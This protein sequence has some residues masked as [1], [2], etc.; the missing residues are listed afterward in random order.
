MSNINGN[1]YFKSYNMPGTFMIEKG[2]CSLRVIQEMN[3]PYVW[4]EFMYSDCVRYNN[5]LVFVPYINAEFI[6]I[7]DTQSLEFTYVKNIGLKKLYGKVKMWNQ[8]SFLTM[9]V[10]SIT[11]CIGLI[12]DMEQYAFLTLKIKLLKKSK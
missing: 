1:L 6:S 5:I 3:K 10:E 2:S 7:L 9:A 11:K 8:P 4:H 12:L